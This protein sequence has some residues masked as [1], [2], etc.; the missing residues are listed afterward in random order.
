MNRRAERQ[1]GIVLSPGFGRNRIA[2]G[3]SPERYGDNAPLLTTSQ[4]HT[5]RGH[6]PSGVDLGG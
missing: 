6:A 2:R 1:S 3:V 4:V 5:A